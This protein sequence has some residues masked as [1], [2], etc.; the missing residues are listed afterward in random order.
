LTESGKAV[1]EQDV[2]PERQESVFACLDEEEQSKLSEYLERLIE[3]LEK[4]QAEGG[5]EP[6]PGPGFRGR[7]RDNPF[8]GDEGRSLAGFL[9]HDPFLARDL[10]HC[11]FGELGP[12]PFTRDDE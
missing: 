2:E 9:G 4:Q 12:V 7:G 10:R 1:S 3:N 11:P 8:R 6:F 5:S